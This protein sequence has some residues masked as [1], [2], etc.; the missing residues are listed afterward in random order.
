MAGRPP[1]WPFHVLRPIT[2]LSNVSQ[3]SPRRGTPWPKKGSW[4]STKFSVD[5]KKNHR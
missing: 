3:R 5:T 4:E 1:P 2:S